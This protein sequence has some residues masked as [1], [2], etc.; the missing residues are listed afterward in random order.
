MS[1]PEEK[2]KAIYHAVRFAKEREAQLRSLPVLNKAEKY[3]LEM[4][5][6]CIK[7][8]EKLLSETGSEP[9]TK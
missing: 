3:E 6:D 4:T 8:G 5:L 1:T 7:R 2:L 9:E